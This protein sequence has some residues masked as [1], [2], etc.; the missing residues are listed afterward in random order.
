MVVELLLK[1][2][3]LQSQLGDESSELLN[4]VTDV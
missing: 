4:L 2:I 3:D 1:G